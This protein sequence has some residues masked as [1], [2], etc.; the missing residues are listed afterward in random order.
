MQLKVMKKEQKITEQQEKP[1]YYNYLEWDI[2]NVY[3]QFQ[4][5]KDKKSNNS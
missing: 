5:N 1:I 4:K 3:N 2:S